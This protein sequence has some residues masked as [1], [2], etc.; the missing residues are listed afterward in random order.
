MSDFLA[1]FALVLVIEGLLYAAAPEAMRR[2]MTVVLAQP[3]GALRIAG[4]AAAIIGVLLLW[5]LRG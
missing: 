4:L 5:L 3:A 2:A 1:A